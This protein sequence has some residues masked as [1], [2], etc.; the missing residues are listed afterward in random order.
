[1]RSPEQEYAAS[2][3]QAESFVQPLSRREAQPDAPRGKQANARASRKARTFFT[4]NTTLFRTS[5]CSGHDHLAHA[6]NR[7]AAADARGRAPDTP[8]TLAPASA[9][10][11]P[12]GARRREAG[13]TCGDAT[14][15]VCDRSGHPAPDVDWAGIGVAGPTGDEQKGKDIEVFVDGEPRDV[16]MGFLRCRVPGPRPCSP[17]GV[18]PLRRKPTRFSTFG[19]SR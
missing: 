15:G 13:V 3:P 2:S 14:I 17:F 9:R 6:A 7:G 19:R 11:E 5:I 10:A 12:R 4:G 1:M 16:A 8:S 18:T